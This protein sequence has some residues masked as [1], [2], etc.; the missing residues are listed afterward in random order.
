MVDIDQI[1][2]SEVLVF[3]WFLLI[4]NLFI[5]NINCAKLSLFL[6]D[7]QFIS[8]V[9]RLMFHVSFSIQILNV[10]QE[11]VFNRLI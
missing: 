11:N 2:H 1:G 3:I 5:W 10:Q 8:Y 9:F 4:H 6:V 7:L